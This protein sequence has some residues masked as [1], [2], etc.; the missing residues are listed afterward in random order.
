[1]GAK[2][3]F[4]DAVSEELPAEMLSFVHDKLDS[5]VKW[6]I[7]RFLK[8]N[9]HAADTQAGLALYVGRRPEVVAPQ[10]QEMADDGLLQ[11]RSVGDMPVYTLTEDPA[12]R[13]LVTR[14]LESCEDRRFR[15]RVVY[16]VAR[17]MR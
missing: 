10:L 17:C 7:L 14:F 9:P 3:G 12:T 2:E 15:L 6:D 1:M 13:D 4:M 16:H 11:V 8:Q 5:F